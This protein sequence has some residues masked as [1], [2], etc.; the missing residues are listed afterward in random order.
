[1]LEIE[2]S[3]GRGDTE[4]LKSSRAKVDEQFVVKG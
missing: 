4:N 1:V 2:T 3:F